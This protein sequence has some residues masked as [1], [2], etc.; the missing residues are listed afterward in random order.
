MRR[1]DSASKAP[2]RCD[3]PRMKLL[4]DALPGSLARGAAR[5]WVDDG[6]GAP[7]R[8]CLRNSRAGE[9]VA[10]VSTTPPGPAGAYEET[11]PVFV[12]ADGCTGPQSPGYPEEFR[13]RPQ[14]FRAYDA[15]GAIIGGEVVPAGRGR[16]RRQSGCWP[17]RRSLS[18]TREMWSTAA[19]CWP[20]A[21]GKRA[22]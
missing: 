20:S 3:A 8:C 22:S 1:R 21:G 4:I 6:G 9:R 15:D 17:T 13:S 11:G 16:R 12:H 7:L 18:C 5:S 14:V 2:G 19:T 10:L